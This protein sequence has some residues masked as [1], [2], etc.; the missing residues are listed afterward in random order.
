VSDAQVGSSP[1]RDV[2]TIFAIPKPFAGHIGTIQGNAIRSWKH[3][4][5]GCEV[6]LCGDEPGLAGAA[7]EF[8]VQRIVEI[9][10][11]AFGTPLVSSA[12]QLVEESAKYDVLCYANAD[13]ILFPDFVD[14]VRRVSSLKRRFLVVGYAWDLEV[15]VALEPE[16]SDWEADLRRSVSLA[17]ERRGANYIDFFVF[18]RGTIGRLPDFAVGRPRWDNWMIWNARSRR[19]PV[20]D[21]SPSALVIHQ[22]HGYGHVKEARDGR[23]AG[24]EGDANQALLRVGQVLGLG[25]ATH[26]LQSGQLVRQPPQGGWRHALATELLLHSWGVHVYHL[27]RKRPRRSSKA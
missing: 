16:E 25:N 22:K 21:I 1:G 12:F 5:S 23:W 7:A 9:A 6:I 26:R 3:L 8:G 18:R 24:P 10:R 20:V 14:S 2:L 15:R 4:G 17:G 11:N 19:L 27:L 13:L